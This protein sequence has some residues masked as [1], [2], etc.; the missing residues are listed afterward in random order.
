VSSVI[1]TYW[2]RAF[3]LFPS[4][5]VCISLFFLKTHTHACTHVRMLAST[6]FTMYRYLRLFT[7]FLA[8]FLAIFNYILQLSNSLYW[9]YNKV[10]IIAS[11]YS[12]QSKYSFNKDILFF[13]YFR[14][15]KS[16]VIYCQSVCGWLFIII[17][18]ICKFDIE[19]FNLVLIC[20]CYCRAVVSNICPVVQKW[21]T[22]LSQVACSW[23]AMIITF[24]FLL[25][26]ILIR[27]MRPY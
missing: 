3:F 20:I 15:E 8:Y 24:S 16:Y 26:A 1:E 27:L 12:I 23:F 14:Y 10:Y 25:W 13:L 9:L 18:Y 11:F 22:T 21:S 2:R 17:K 6:Y 5:V 4:I 7:A 19:A